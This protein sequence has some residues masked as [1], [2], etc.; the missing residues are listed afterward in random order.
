[1]KN[2]KMLRSV[3]VTLMTLTILAMSITGAFAGS[4]D[5]STGTATVAG[6]APTVTLP[7][8]WNLVEDTNEN[9]TGLDPWT[10]YHLNFTVTDSS[11]LAALDNVTIFVWDN[12]TAVEADADA[13]I[14]HL[15]YTWTEGTDTWACPLSANYLVSA[16]C[17]DPGTASGATTYEFR[18]AFKLP[19]V[20]TYQNGATYTAWRIRVYA[21]DDSDNSGNIN[22]ICHGVNFYAELTV[23][24]DTTHAWSTVYPGTT[25]NLITSPGDNDVDFTIICNA[26]FDVEAE[27]NDTVLHSGANTIPIANVQVDSTTNTTA[28][29]L[30]SGY[31]NTDLV[32]QAA[33]TADTGTSLALKVWL[34]VP[35]G[36]LPGDYVYELWIK[37]TKT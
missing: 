29:H 21:Y 26:V 1:M 16:N 3:L 8:L 37:V 17:S 12:V 18:L 35:G 6:V 34:D 9:N 31:Q 22:T 14:E 23:P 20:A 28:L 24:S 19:K 15:T 11:S 2:N 25:G 4:S 32:S 5:K 33:P 30:T 36:T 7:E 13:Q 27:A 10:E